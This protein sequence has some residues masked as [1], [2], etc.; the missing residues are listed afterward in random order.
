M[1]A[2]ACVMRAK[3][4]AQL[5]WTK[6]TWPEANIETGRTPILSL[7]MNAGKMPNGS[8][9]PE[10]FLVR[11]LKAF[12]SHTF[13]CSSCFTHST[14]RSM[15]VHHQSAG[16]WAPAAWP[17]PGC[18]VC[19]GKKWCRQAPTRHQHPGKASALSKKASTPQQ[20]IST[21][22]RHQNCSRRLQY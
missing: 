9:W 12:W 13:G 1:R 5:A 10:P 22:A 18:R 11:S 14:V 4:R 15:R 16:S 19:R 8:E 20:G 3:R 21:P 6:K 2:R 17:P 7:P